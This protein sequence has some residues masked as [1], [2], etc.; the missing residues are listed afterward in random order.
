L[1]LDIAL[2]QKQKAEA[3]STRAEIEDRQRKD[4]EQT[5]QTRAAETFRSAVGKTGIRFFMEEEDL[6][7][8]LKTMHYTVTASNA[9]DSFR[10]LDENGKQIELERAIEALGAKHPNLIQSGGEHLLPLRDETGAYREPARSDYT[11]LAAKSRY[12]SE[13]GLSRWEQMSAHPTKK[14]PTSQL[15]AKSYSRLSLREKSALVSEIGEAG[16]SEIL[17]RR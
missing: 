2:L 6:K 12:I 16:V 13:F 5:R 14:A 15:D 10:V 1:Q 7:T 4:Q 3:E 9:G 11:T 17:R 8:V